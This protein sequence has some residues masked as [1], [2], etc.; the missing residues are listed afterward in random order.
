MSL[1]NKGTTFGKLKFNNHIYEIF[2]RPL[3]DDI[4]DKIKKY[5]KL[6]K[7]GMTTNPW[8]TNKYEWEIINNKIYLTFIYLF[9]G[10]KNFHNAKLK[11]YIF[12]IFGTDK[13]FADWLN[14]DIKLL[15]SKK[16]ILEPDNTMT[17]E[18]KY[19]I[20]TKGR[21]FV[22][23]EVKVL[24]FSNGELINESDCFIEKY[25]EK[26]RLKDYIEE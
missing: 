8:H 10:F 11:N 13:I 18:E 4:A 17:E 12:D 16:D 5:K 3:S 19:A 6:H 23:R 14:K 2:S 15:I 20:A 9:D 25:I 21:A 1:P 24:S 26:M 22:Q 7:V